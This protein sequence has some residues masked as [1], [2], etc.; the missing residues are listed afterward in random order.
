[1]R[2]LSALVLYVAISLSFAQSAHAVTIDVFKVYSPE[3]IA[4][5]N[6]A[7]SVK[8]TFSASELAEL[9]GLGQLMEFQVIAS[10][11][12]IF[13]TI[14][15]PTSEIFSNSVD[16]MYIASREFVPDPKVSSGVY[17]DPFLL[18][19]RYDG[20]FYQT[21]ETPLP[22]SLPLVATGLAAFGL[23]R[24]LR[25]EKPGNTGHSSSGSLP[26]HTQ[27]C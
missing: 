13:G 15:V 18:Y 11:G 5:D 21:A 27:E 26:N 9:K 23:V 14:Y 19:V 20:K 10:A 22:A 25:K 4:K 12:V 24:R 17:D 8:L 7:F 2:L 3:D 6:P 16:G 1:M